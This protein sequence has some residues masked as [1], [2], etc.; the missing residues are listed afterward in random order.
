MLKTILNVTL[1][2]ILSC[3]LFRRSKPTSP[4]PS[5]EV[6]RR[7]V[8]D[9]AVVFVHGFSGDVTTWAAFID[10]LKV[11]KSINSWDIFSLNYPT[12]LRVDIPNLWSADPEIKTLSTELVTTLS[13]LPFNQYK[14]I[15]LVAH[16]M[17]GLV[18]QQAIVEDAGL[19]SRLSHVILFGTPS[20]GLQKATLGTFFKRQLRDMSSRSAFIKNLRAGWTSKFTGGLPFRFMVLQGDRDEF[21]SGPS[22][23]SPFAKELQGVIPG[24]HL[25]IVRPND[26][27]Y[28]G[29]QLVLQELS[30]VGKRMAMVD[31]ARLAVELGE[32]QEAVNSL[33]PCVGQIDEAAM[34]TLA[35]ALDGLSRSEQALELLEEHC[36]KT[37]A[38]AMGVLGGRIKRR[39]LTQRSALDLGRAKEL[40]GSGLNLALQ[41]DDYS[42]AY[43]HAINLAFLDLI[44]APANSRIPDS[45]TTM[46]RRALDYCDLADQN[47]WCWATRGEAHLILKDQAKAESC[48]RI[49]LDKAQSPRE[50]Q[51]MYSQAIRVGLRTGGE[52][53]G[54]AIERI[55]GVTEAPNE[56]K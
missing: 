44:S 7:Q 41:N 19:A 26:R 17:G 56:K 32:F 27:D 34:V 38:D 8:Q 18:V 54:R 49:A 33:L 50:R 29:F 35:L 5:V 3:L 16:S 9:A 51:S 30:G 14:R 24:N 52:E 40:Y 12:G 15:A 4:P 6:H 1:T 13:A 39:W 31:G 25:E 28:L 47:L 21:V 53:S 22:S 48:Y 42:Q 36:N 11:E 43:Y 55:F 23:L 10:L 2:G 20:A 37:S 46:A 45:V